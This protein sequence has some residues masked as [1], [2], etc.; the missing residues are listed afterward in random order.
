MQ[1]LGLSI[2]LAPWCPGCKDDTTFPKQGH[3]GLTGRA[4][5]QFA[6]IAFQERRKPPFCGAKPLSCFGLC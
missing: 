2:L 4:E 1:F 3:L 5:C 6:F